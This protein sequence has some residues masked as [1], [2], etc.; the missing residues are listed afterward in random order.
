MILII[1][2]K[3]TNLSRH[4]VTFIDIFGHPTK[5]TPLKQKSRHN[6]EQFNKSQHRSR[7]VGKE[8]PFIFDYITIY[9][10]NGKNPN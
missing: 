9:S 8:D 1:N 6:G 3:K 4:P 2:F 7:S 10:K 5:N